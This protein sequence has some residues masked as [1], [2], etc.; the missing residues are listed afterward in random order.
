MIYILSRIRIKVE[1]TFVL[2]PQGVPFN[3]RFN[4]SAYLRTLTTEAL[5]NTSRAKMNNKLLAWAKALLVVLP[6]IDDVCGVYVVDD[7]VGLG[8]MFNGIGGLSG[9]GV[10]Q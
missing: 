2:L 4:N 3:A 8:R 9:G 1:S 7:S 5:S 10:S 6:L